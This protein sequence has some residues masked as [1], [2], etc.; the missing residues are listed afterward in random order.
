GRLT[1][2]LDGGEQQADED[3]DDRYHHQQLDQRETARTRPNLG[4]DAHAESSFGGRNHFVVPAGGGNTSVGIRSTRRQKYPPGGR[5]A[6][7]SI[8]ISRGTL[9]VR[10]AVLKIRTGGYLFA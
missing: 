6:P 1:D 3:G 8:T 4:R 2:L 7:G 5:A 9:G 10:T